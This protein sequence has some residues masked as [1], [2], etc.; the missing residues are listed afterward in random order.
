[1]P[2]YFFEISYDGTHYHGWQRQENAMS[3]QQKVE[4]ALSLLTRQP[5]SITGSGRTDTGVHC[6]QQFFHCDFEKTADTAQL[7]HKLNS[8]LP[9]DIS[10][11]AI[12][13]VANDIHARFTAISRSYE[14]RISLRK[15]P[16]LEKYACHFHK[17]LDVTRMNEAALV[18]L[19]EE[20]FQA[21]SKVKTEVENFRCSISTARWIVG[22]E[23]LTFEITANRFLR[24]MVR[25]IV[26][27]LLDVGTAKRPTEDFITI[28]KSRDR[29]K[30]G[31]AA[32]AQGLFLTSVKY[33]E[34]VM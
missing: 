6:E 20:D 10:I 7:Q 4:E 2:R 12:F 17:P 21:F 28:I 1:M 27:T 14:Y 26:G 13:Q 16:F 5:M 24:G 31:S 9:N 15:N 8:L 29:R 22:D 33:P 25:A 30:A 23:L 34:K 3:I 18:L 11:N 19:E 32:P